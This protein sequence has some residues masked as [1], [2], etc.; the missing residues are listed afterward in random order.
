M[1]T[2]LLVD[3]NATARLAVQKVLQ[4]DGYAVAEAGTCRAALEQFRNLRPDAVVV[5][6]RLPDGTALDL[7]SDVK[8]RDIGTP[9][10][11][12]AEF[13]TLPLAVEAIQ[14]GA[15]QFL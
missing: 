8:A 3:D 6:C 15:E 5:S 11:V 12:L 9:C 1:H 13:E 7:L 14:T 10:I 4:A 2:V